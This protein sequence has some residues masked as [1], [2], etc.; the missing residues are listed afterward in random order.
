MPWIG[1]LVGALIGGSFKGFT[2]ALVGAVVGVV[3]GA[4]LRRSLAANRNRGAAASGTAPG[5]TLRPA[6]AETHEHV[7][8]ARVWRL[9]QRLRQLEAALAR[10]GITLPPAGDGETTASSG[11]A[12]V[13]AP[14]ATIA[15]QGHDLPVRKGGT[16]AGAPNATT[17]RPATPGTAAAPN[18][19][20]AWFTGGATIVRIGV[21]VLFFGVAFLLSYLAE[22][23]TVPVELKFGGVALCGIALIAGGAWLRRSRPNYALA[24]IAGGLGVLYLTTFAALHWVPLLAPPVALALLVAISILAVV[25][26]LAFDAQA[27]AALAAIGGFLAPVLVPAIDAPLVLFGYV[28]L[29]NGVLLAIAWFRSWRVLNLFGFAFTF[30][31]GLWWG[32]EYYRP[33]YLTTV[34]PFLV[35]YFVVYVAISVLNATRGR[36]AGRI[37]GPVDIDAA[38]TFGVPMA[39]F[40]L[41]ALLVQDLPYGLAWSAMIIAALY[42]LLWLALRRSASAPVATLATAHAALALVFVTLAVPLAVDQRWTSATWAVEAAGVY[43]LGCKQRRPYARYFALLL[44]FGTGA[45]FL[46]AGADDQGTT[47]FLNR[48][49]LGAAVI[50]LS[51]LAIV[52]LGDRNRDDQPP[53]ERWVLNLALVWGCAWWLGGGMA[54][55]ARQFDGK[56]RTHALLAWVAGSVAVALPLAQALGSRRFAAATIVLLPALALALAHDVWHGGTTLTYLGWLLFPLAWALQFGALRVAEGW[57]SSD[58]ADA[59]ELR[60]RTTA[61][62]WLTGWHALGALLLLAQLSW[63]AGEWTARVTAGSTVWAACAHLVPLALYLIVVS[64]AWRPIGLS[65]VFEDAYTLHAGR[66]VAIALVLGFVAL[67]LLNP[68]N[69]TPLPYVPLLN[70]LEFTLALALAALFAWTSAYSGASRLAL[71]RWLGVG[72][73]IA[74]NGIVVRTV[75]HWLGVRW[76]FDDLIASKPLQAALTLTWTV[77]ALVLMVVATRHKVR[78]PWL[79]GAGLLAAVIVKLFAIDLAALTGLPRIVAF[80]GVGVLLLIIGYVAPLPPAAKDETGATEASAAPGP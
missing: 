18:A 15:A 3:V 34:E 42:C 27:L 10:A 5:P 2:G 24:L 71:Y 53:G 61:R 12:P 55:V 46:F 30:V 38:L 51:A 75:H 6:A 11:G 52:L 64:R 72:A 13:S 48:Q 31:L 17:E 76:R 40:A 39:A 1:L 58:P 35:L 67:A 20:W 70:P 54:E 37:A 43:W 29:L 49:F 56:I 22:H 21:V 66:I 41:Q 19:V 50:A 63:E 73:F 45:A 44:Q 33:E 36:T 59:K 4:L 77:A 74:L 57:L 8:T 25:L 32:Q 28:A 60:A 16:G 78:G 23:F 80:L 47:L 62:Q 65:P 68:G 79:V 14:A 26:A 9:E 7:L 69:A